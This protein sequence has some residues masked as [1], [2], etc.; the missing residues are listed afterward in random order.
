MST[1]YG[2]ARNSAGYGVFR[3][4]LTMKRMATFYLGSMLL[5]SAL[6]LLVT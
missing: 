1:R 2:I 3:T 6:V 5:I 4:D